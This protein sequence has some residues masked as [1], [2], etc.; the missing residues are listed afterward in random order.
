VGINTAIYSETGN[1]VGYS[2]AI[3]VSIVQKV[4]SD[5]KQYGTVQ[6][7]L[8]GVSVSELS[9]LR[10]TNPDIYNNLKVTEGVY[11]GGF[12]PNSTAEKAGMAIGDV[13]TAINGSKVRSFGELQGLLSRFN[14]GDKINVQV[15]RGSSEKTFSVG[16]V[17][18]Q[19]TT[20]VTKAQ[21][22]KDVLGASFKE[23]SQDD[24]MN[25][26]INFGVEVTDL[27]DGKLKAAGI[28]SGFI[29][30]TANDV[31]VSSEDDL[32]RIVQAILRQEPDNRGLFL[33][34]FYPN[35]KKVEY[36]AIDLSN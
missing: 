13:I 24:K 7:A 5:L 31:R 26:G 8:L 28:K 25:L 15:Q 12:S 19:G 22:P 29:I 35:V 33:R 2:F 36:I 14:P 11:V 16:L 23:L 34:G 18:D 27:K 32:T 21:P 3:P 17:N 30:L 10:E 4:I 9:A 1:F 6:R 20:Q